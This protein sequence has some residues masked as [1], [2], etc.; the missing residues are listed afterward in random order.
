MSA[1]GIQSIT[2]ELSPWRAWQHVVSRLECTLDTQ[3]SISA[4]V[5]DRHDRP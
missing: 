1:L 5:G 2:V 3:V 4:C